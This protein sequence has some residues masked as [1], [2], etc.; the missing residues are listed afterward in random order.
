MQIGTF[1]FMKG[2]GAAMGRGVNNFGLSFLVEKGADF[3][4]GVGACFFFY[5]RDVP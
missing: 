1:F 4:K 5:A 2:P 3:R